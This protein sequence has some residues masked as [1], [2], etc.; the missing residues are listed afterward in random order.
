MSRNA[1]RMTNSL[2]LLRQE[3]LLPELE[4]WVAPGS[5]AGEMLRHPLVYDLAVRAVPGMANNA[6]LKKR[7]A[8]IEHMRA[9]EWAE[10]LH[11]YERPYRMGKLEWMWRR[12]KIDKEEMRDLLARWWTDTEIPQGNQSEPLFLFREAHFTTDDEESWYTLPDVLV[13]YRG[14]DWDFEKT[15]DGP[16]WTLS[17][18][19]ARFFAY[20][21]GGAERGGSVFMYVA[22]KAEVLAFFT[23]R[24]EEEIIL[25]FERVSAP[26]GIE[27]V[28]GPGRRTRS[29]D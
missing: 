2:L 29:R 24:S 23:G 17:L 14:V 12:R 10:I 7:A 22:N 20:R 16:S 18:E 13:A 11:L 5:V 27:L 19:V 6:Y 3:P 21:L 26:S 15:R 25:D 28:E 8:V 9:G 4:R 1:K